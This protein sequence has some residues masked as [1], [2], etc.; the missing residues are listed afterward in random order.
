MVDI[1]SYSNSWSDRHYA[2]GLDHG[3]KKIY[4]KRSLVL[5]LQLPIDVALLTLFHFSNLRGNLEVIFLTTRWENLRNFLANEAL[6]GFIGLPVYFK[7]FQ[8]T[9]CKYLFVTPIYIVVTI[10]LFLPKS[11][12]KNFSHFAVLL[13]KL[14][15]RKVTTHA[16]K[17]IV[18][19]DALPFARA[20]VIAANELGLNTICIQHGT[21]YENHLINERDGFLCNINIVRSSLD[22]QIIKSANKNT[23]LH[24]ASNF[25]SPKISELKVASRDECTILLLGEGFHAVDKN[26]NNNYLA[27]VKKLHSYFTERKVK[28]I[29][30]PHPSESR[31]IWAKYFNDVDRGRLDSTLANVD[32]VVGFSSSVLLEAAQIG[33]PSFHIAVEGYSRDGLDRDGLIVKFLHHPDEVI[34]AAKHYFINNENNDCKPSDNN[35][36]IELAQFIISSNSLRISHTSL[37]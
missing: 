32:A 29:F 11:M 22:G 19:S 2:K 9:K 31:I 1:Y 18:H 4:L 3:L 6:M 21:F 10:G 7:F 24:V 37:N 5:F 20:Y 8:K 26:F 35:S 12:Q 17:I 25:F 28:C 34:L 27:A 15:L 13:A 33:I 16:S 36:V 30:R 23:I 14:Q